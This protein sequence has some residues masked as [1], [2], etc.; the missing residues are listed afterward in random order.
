MKSKIFVNTVFFTLVGFFL[1]AYLREFDF[2][3][4]QGLSVDYLSLSIAAVL[5]LIF[6]YWGVYTWKAILD[7]LGAEHLPRFRVLSKIYSKAWLGRYIPGKVTWIAGKVLFASEHG[8][9]KKK[10]AVS[11][12]LE[13]LVQVVAIYFISLL[14][15]LPDYRFSAVNP[16][17]RFGLM[18]GGVFLTMTLIPSVFNWLIKITLRVVRKTE[19][20]EDMVI[21]LEVMKHAFWLYSIS[22][23]FTGASYYFLT[24]AVQPIK[25]NDLFYVMAVFNIAGSI[26]IAS[27][28]TPSGLGVREGIQ[29]LLLVAIMPKEIA[30]VVTA[31]ARLFSITMDFLFFAISQLCLIPKEEFDRVS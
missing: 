21:N 23:F 29:M 4:I 10:L 22:Y 27:M 18:A 19:L 8:I 28:I 31:F 14:F 25:I 7:R 13:A 26:G 16:L 3:K 17:V 20:L 24:N 9:S 15:L 12:V 30:L 6:R 2:S 5:A 1:V 11:S